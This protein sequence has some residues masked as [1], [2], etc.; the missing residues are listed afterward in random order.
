M[1]IKVDPEAV[2]QAFIALGDYEPENPRF[3]HGGPLSL[4]GAIAAA[5]GADFAGALIYGRGGNARYRVDRDGSVSLYA[6]SCPS[7]VEQA[8]ALGFGIA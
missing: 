8:R 2:L 5:Q 6:D 4:P 7:K 1:N 3:K